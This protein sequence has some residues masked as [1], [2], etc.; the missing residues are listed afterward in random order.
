MPTTVAPTSDEIIEFFDSRARYAEALGTVSTTDEREVLNLGLQRFLV[1]TH[2]A[3]GSWISF[4]VRTDNVQPT[5][6]VS[7]IGIDLR[8][9]LLELKLRDGGYLAGRER[10]VRTVAQGGAK[11]SIPHPLTAVLDDIDAAGKAYNSGL[12]SALFAPDPKMLEHEIHLERQRISSVMSVLESAGVASAKAHR[13]SLLIGFWE[14]TDAGWHSDFGNWSACVLEV[15]DGQG[16]VVVRRLPQSPI[17]D[18]TW[19]EI[20]APD[21]FADHA[22]ATVT[23]WQRGDAS[24]VIAPLLGYRD[25]D[26]RMMDLE[27]PLG[28]MMRNT[29]DVIGENKLDS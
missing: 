8:D 5:Q 2:T 29:H 4:E 23:S 28:K 27:T 26:A 17:D 6:D 7:G 11:P 16:A 21:V 18:S 24:S 22:G 1:D 13:R 25:R 3:L 10:I 9:P 15:E 19:S 20:T 14:N 12:R